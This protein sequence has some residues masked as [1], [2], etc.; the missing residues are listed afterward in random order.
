MNALGTSSTVHKEHAHF[1]FWLSFILSRGYNACQKLSLKFLL[2]VSRSS[3]GVRGRLPSCK[4]LCSLL[5]IFSSCSS[6][7]WCSLSFSWMNSLP[8]SL[9][10]TIGWWWI[11]LAWLIR[12][13]YF[14]NFSPHPSQTF[15]SL[16]WR[17]SNQLLCNW[18]IVAI[19]I[20]TSVPIE[21]RAPR[22]WCKDPQRNDSLT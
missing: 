14:A 5:S 9:H 1:C 7:T 16:W 6:L 15:F 18:K 21:W 11:C 17:M 12:S 20:C 22:F 19:N 13:S 8:H 4:F 10:F 3:W 2:W